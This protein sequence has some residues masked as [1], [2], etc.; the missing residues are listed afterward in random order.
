MHRFA[1]PTRF[2]RFSRAVAP[3][4][5]ASAAAAIV[6]GLAWGLLVAPPDYQQGDSVR[7]MFVHVPAA[8]MGMMIYAVLAAAGAALLVWRHPLAAVAAK[9]AAPI[10]A[11]FTAICLITG[12]L[13]GKPMWGTW[14]VWDARLTSM[15][16]L[17]FLYFGHMALSSAFDDSERGA[18]A[19]AILALVGVINLVVIKFSVDWWYTLHQ[20]ASVLRLGGSTIDISMLLP[21][22]IMAA[23][24]LLYFV[25]LL[26]W[27]IEAELAARKLEVASLA[28]R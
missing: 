8:W 20:P 14:W 23:G 4:T 3:Y 7:I 6:I 18:R 21:L 24:Y 9:A 27:R 13:W 5:G 22:L 12:S 19:A 1:N 17:L 10:G 28:D 16:L 26:A 25:T 15:L 11:A 2:L